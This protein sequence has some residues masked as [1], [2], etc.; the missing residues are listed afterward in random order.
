MNYTQ[1]SKKQARKNTIGKSGNTI[2]AANVRETTKMLQA[3]G[4]MAEASEPDK[5]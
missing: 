3:I 1:P 4:V 5:N 2:K